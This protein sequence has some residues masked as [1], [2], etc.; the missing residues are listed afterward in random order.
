[1]SEQGPVPFYD[2][3]RP[4]SKLEEKYLREL[5]RAPQ[6]GELMNESVANL[7]VR[8]SKYELKPSSIK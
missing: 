1:M 2:A 6:R 7:K 8:K 4:L 3:A 5:Q